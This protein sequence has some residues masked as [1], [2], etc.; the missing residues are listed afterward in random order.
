MP[1][2]EYICT[3]CHNEFEE[4]Q[5]FSDDPSRVCPKCSKEKVEKKVSL[6]GFQLKGEGW[7]KDGYARPSEKS[8]GSAPASKKG[9]DKSSKKTE[10]KESKPKSTSSTTTK[11]L[12][13]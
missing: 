4:I 1:L 3:A 12:A 7:Y 5:K 11:N 2:Y 9:S 10:K 6:S 13:A 8:G